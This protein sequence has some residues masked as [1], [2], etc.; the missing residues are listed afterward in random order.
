MAEKKTQ[1][2]VAR[3]MKEWRNSVKTVKEAVKTA[4]AVIVSFFY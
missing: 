1:Q 3:R 2:A 4:M